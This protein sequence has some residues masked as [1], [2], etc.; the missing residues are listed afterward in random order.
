MN[1]SSNS[2]RLVPATIFMG[3]LVSFIFTSRGGFSTLTFGDSADYLESARS[4]SSNEGFYRGES[5]WPF[6]RPPGYPFAIAFL[7]ELAGSESIA[8]LKILNLFL[9]LF[10]AFLVFKLASIRFNPRVSL[11]ATSLYLFNPFALIPLNEVQTETITSFL[12]L[13]FILLIVARSTVFRVLALSF[14]SVFLIA[15]RPEYLIFLVLT[16]FCILVFQPARQKY[17][18]K[19]LILTIS[20]VLCLS[21]WGFQ[22]KKATGDFILLTNAG[23]YFLWNGSTDL[24]LD[25]YIISLKP[26][27]DYDLK[28]YNALQKEIADLKSSWGKEFEESS[29]AQKSNYWFQA[30]ADNVKRDPP[31][32]IL[33]TLEKGIIFMRPFLN[34]RSH[35]LG[36]AIVSLFVLL[37][38]TASVGYATFLAARRKIYDPIL[39][40]MII[41]FLSIMMVHMLQM[42]D[43]RYKMPIFV[44]L[45]AYSSGFVVY[46]ILQRKSNLKVNVKE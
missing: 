21:W 12:F 45:F 43:Q 5:T 19:I 14:V 28:T 24:V 11:I 15:V 40:I 37:P 3:V 27:P 23:S 35:G 38:M 22:N 29:L 46:A 33:K 44:P 2:K 4:V 16:I 1:L 25:N 26:D 9:H 31:R 8:A 36:V 17:F 13:S 41:G 6:F 34:P 39:G 32:Y 10:S 30:Y 42:P 18:I 20:L 7:W